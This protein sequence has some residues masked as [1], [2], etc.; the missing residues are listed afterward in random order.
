MQIIQ[1]EFLIK[2]LEEL[3]TQI[4]Y[5]HT[6]SAKIE[7]TGPKF[8]RITD[9][10]EG[11]VD[12]ETVPTCECD[13]DKQE[14][15]R[16]EAGDIVFARTGATTGKTFL[17]DDCPESTV[18]ASYL[19]RIR[20][21]KEILS[22]Y[23]AYFFQ[24]SWYWHQISMRATGSAQ[25]GVN[26]TKLKLLKIPVPSLSQQERIVAILD[27]VFAAIASATANVKKNLTNAQEVFESE[28]NRVFSEKGEGWQVKTLDQICEIARGGSPRPIKQYLT[29]DPDGINWIKI[30]DAT[31][32]TKY[33]YS[34]K[35]KIKQEGAKRSRV[36]KEG[37]F[38]LSNSMSFG[39]P[40]IMKTSGCIHDGWLVLRDKSG[41]FN[42]DYLYH[43]LGSNAAYHQF[44][45][46]A[47]GS[48]VRNL[49]INLVSSVEVP[50]P[51]INK[52]EEIVVRLDTL[53]AKK[54]A[55]LDLYERK[56]EVLNELKQ[57]ILSNAFTGDFY[58]DK[59][60]IKPVTSE[61]GL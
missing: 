41:V 5:G 27:D 4:D 21:S 10:Q 31:A 40:Y 8:L 18:F 3:T 57:S 34:T 37:D 2:T 23:L 14:K 19:I 54:Q 42:Q 17:V 6:A 50:V 13:P 12:W 61:E 20:P 39:R 51:P 9:I 46:R 1:S 48:T 59:K 16:L 15:Y 58:T 28:L 22:E 33:I 26:A 47:S 25:P 44:D 35:Q 7:G 24:S 36:V 29:D 52:Q 49:N 53:L 11:Q 38:L 55:L 30:S 32:S 43:F 60:D 56:L 45:S